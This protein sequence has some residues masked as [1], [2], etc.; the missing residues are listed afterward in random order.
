MVRDHLHGPKAP[1]VWRGLDGEVQLNEF[2]RIAVEELQR[3]VSIR[4]ELVLDE[5]I[6]MPNHVH[7]VHLIVF[8]PDADLT[9]GPR[10]ILYRP[11][12]SLGSFIG[13]FKSAVTSRARALFGNAWLEVWQYKFYEHG[14]RADRQLDRIRQYIRDNPWNWEY[15]PEHP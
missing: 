9:S 3:S 10:P 7:H 8:I 15:D 1:V 5:F 11:R 6:V 14:I 4:P 2:G 12:R 13:G